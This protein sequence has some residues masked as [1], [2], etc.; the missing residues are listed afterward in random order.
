MQTQK[1]RSNA[2]CSQFL[3]RLTSL[4]QWL[5]IVLKQLDG[6]HQDL[7]EAYMRTINILH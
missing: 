7:G 3:S 2:T 4:F 5:V 6:P 1:S